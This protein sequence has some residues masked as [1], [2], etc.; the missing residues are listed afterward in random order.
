MVL[1]GAWA[2]CQAAEWIDAPAA[3]IAEELMAQAAEMPE[4]LLETVACV[5]RPK[6]LPVL[7]ELCRRRFDRRHATRTLV[8]RPLLDWIE[9]NSR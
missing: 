9:G 3:E 2:E 7:R 5:A 6:R 1:F 8:L 4:L